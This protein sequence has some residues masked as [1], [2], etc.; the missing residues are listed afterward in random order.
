MTYHPSHEILIKSLY[1]PV[2]ARPSFFLNEQKKSQWPKHVYLRDLF[3]A[4]EY[5]RVLLRF[6]K[7]K[8]RQRNIPQDIEP[9]LQV[10]I[11][12]K[13]LLQLSEKTLKELHV[14]IEFAWKMDN[15]T[16]KYS[17]TET[18]HFGEYS[19]ALINQQFKKQLTPYYRYPR[20]MT[21]GLK[22]KKDMV[23]NQSISHV[24]MIASDVPLFNYN[25]FKISVTELQ[26]QST[27]PE[28]LRTILR[29]CTL[30]ASE[31]INMWNDQLSHILDDREN[32]EKTD[33]Y[34]FDE[35]VNLKIDEDLKLWHANSTDNTADNFRPYHLQELAQF[36]GNILT[37]LINQVYEGKLPENKEIQAYPITPIVTPK[38]LDDIFFN[39]QL[40]EPCIK[41]LSTVDPP[42][43]MGNTLKYY[44]TAVG[45]WF[46]ELIHA[47]VIPFIKPDQYDAML[48]TRIVV[49]NI[50]KGSV[51]AKYV[52]NEKGEAYRLQFREH[53]KEILST[54]NL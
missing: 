10:S 15:P 19:V 12:G 1:L 54:H 42:L 48:A 11:E 31:N 38:S 4:I 6:E 21:P 35:D 49:S 36:S 44:K 33:K 3:E 18:L 16:R 23:L 37:F 25:S 29:S 8:Q 30:A 17:P 9:S 24:I 2:Y 45:I 51:Y 32:L 5:F 41:I 43:V 14:S 39:P 53:L 52:K 7:G 50:T 20:K 47:K 40:I 26:L 22:T 27:G 28:T 13:S 46:E 34:I